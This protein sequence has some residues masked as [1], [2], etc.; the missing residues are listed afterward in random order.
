MTA[1]LNFAGNVDIIAGRQAGRLSARVITHTRAR[2]SINYK[3]RARSAYGVPYA[4]QL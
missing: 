4:R 1:T 3:S 2:T